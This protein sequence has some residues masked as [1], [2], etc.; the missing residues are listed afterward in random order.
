[1]VVSAAV[2]DGAWIALDLGNFFGDRGINAPSIPELSG[3]AHNH[4]L[5][6]T[7]PNHFPQIQRGIEA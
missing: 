2:T 5:P 4:L 6:D 7:K 1:M 3:E